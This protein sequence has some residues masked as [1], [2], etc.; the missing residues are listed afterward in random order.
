VVVA[1]I[2][3]V[4]QELTD[5]RP[6]VHTMMDLT[7]DFTKTTSEGHGGE[8]PA[9]PDY[10]GDGAGAMALARPSI[11]AR[12]RALRVSRAART[13]ELGA[14]FLA[15]AELH[16]CGDASSRSGRRCAAI[17]TDSR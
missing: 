12:S 4:M 10:R 8:R 3:F 13:L 16:R 15:P 6:L 9:R 11:S 1:V 17:W 7:V 14:R 5:D 2:A